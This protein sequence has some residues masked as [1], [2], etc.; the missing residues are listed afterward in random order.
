MS[1]DTHFPMPQKDKAVVLPPDH[2]LK[3]QV[4]TLVPMS[5]I[6]DE[7]V[8]KDAENSAQSILEAEREN[9]LFHAA[10]EVGVLGA[11]YHQLHAGQGDKAQHLK[12]MEMMCLLLK[13][14]AGLFGFDLAEKFATSL[15]SLV[16]MQ[17]DLDET[18]LLLLESH[19]RCLE[20]IFD[21]Q[22]TNSETKVAENLLH[23]FEL[24]SEKIR[25][26]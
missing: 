10:E 2:S 1:D 7:D 11:L 19:V 24:I 22:V 23:E 25:R 9:Y 18:V 17:V 6:L 20:I 26:L 3:E 16:R 8:V 13:S 12:D 21:H 15:Y 4:G 5:Y 14:R